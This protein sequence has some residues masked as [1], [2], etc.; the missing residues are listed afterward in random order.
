MTR[1][2]KTTSA[3]IEAP[4][5]SYANVPADFMIRLPWHPDVEIRP[6]DLVPEAVAYLLQY[7]A[8]KTGQDAASGLLKRA[9]TIHKAIAD[10]KADDVARKA[11]AGFCKDIGVSL[12]GGLALPAEEFSRRVATAASESRWADVVAGK[13]D[14]PGTG[15]RLSGIERIVRDL[16]ENVLRQRAKARGRTLDAETLRMLVG[17]M[18]AR[19]D[20]T[21]Q[22]IR[23]AA[24]EQMRIRD[25]LTGVS[26][27]TGQ[28][29]SDDVMDL[30]NG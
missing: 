20:E 30:L 5:L 4:S 24:E 14:I 3:A 23:K 22:N 19:D 2:P 11:Y 12:D 1:T 18:M 17:Q 10:G 16:T 7:G 28:S 21:M 6:S 9:E 25:A 13:M 15:N 29:A 26:A 8:N 27:S